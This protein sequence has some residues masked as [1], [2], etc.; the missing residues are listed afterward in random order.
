MPEGHARVPESARE[1]RS[2]TEYKIFT[3][4]GART[5][6]QVA[7]SLGLNLRKTAK[8]PKR[9]ARKVLQG[10][11]FHATISHNLVSLV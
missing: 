2:G 1:T 10:E 11:K 4:K 9:L 8:A 6:W 3:V 7:S 5:M